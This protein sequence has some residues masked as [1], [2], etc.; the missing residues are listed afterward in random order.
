[1]YLVSS[2]IHSEQIHTLKTLVVYLQCLMVF[3]VLWHTATISFLFEKHKH[4]FLFFF[5]NICI[6]NWKGLK[7]ITCTRW[8]DRGELHVNPFCKFWL[9]SFPPPPP[10][11]MQVIALVFSWQ[12][13][14]GFL[15]VGGGG[16]G[17]LPDTLRHLHNQFPPGMNKV[18]CYCCYC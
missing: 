4:L 1:M 18:Y 7:I 14:R 8:G 17:S 6:Y 9:C 16:G 10:P 11:P 5:S 12:A 2:S 13:L 3:P 15:C